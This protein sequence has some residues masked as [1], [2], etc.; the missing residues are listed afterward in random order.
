MGTDQ[1]PADLC[2]K[3]IKANDYKKWEFYHKGPSFLLLPTS[4]WPPARP[5]KLE[6]ELEH[7]D[8]SAQLF[9]MLSEDP[10]MKDEGFEETSLEE[11]VLQERLVN[12]P[13][14]LLAIEGTYGDPELEVEP[15]TY[16]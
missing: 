4:E 10:R 5:T 12:T 8:G 14:Q 2:S 9:A 11:D 1:N 15:Q 16:G 3:G 6:S 7:Q 13:L